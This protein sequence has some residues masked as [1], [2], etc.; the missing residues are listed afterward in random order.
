MCAA[1]L[2]LDSIKPGDDRDKGRVEVGLVSGAYGQE[3]VP[4][5]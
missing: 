1:A 4:N 3:F 5:S 2:D